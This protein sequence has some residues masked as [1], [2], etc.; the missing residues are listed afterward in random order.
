M[1]PSQ[2]LDNHAHNFLWPP[3]SEPS[4]SGHIHG[5]FHGHP[6]DEKSHFH[7][8]S[9]FLC[10]PFRILPISLFP[11]HAFHQVDSCALSF[12]FAMIALSLL[13]KQAL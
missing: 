11:N 10:L 2:T 8:H 3:T 4:P 5:H 12:Q 6:E 13:L 1:L 9:S 7:D